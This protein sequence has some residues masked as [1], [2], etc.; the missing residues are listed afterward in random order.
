MGR[1]SYWFV[2]KPIED[3]ENNWIQNIISCHL[4]ISLSLLTHR[5]CVKICFEVYF[6]FWE[7]LT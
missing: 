4:L 7:I 6:N 3:I 5:I 1:Q 2:H